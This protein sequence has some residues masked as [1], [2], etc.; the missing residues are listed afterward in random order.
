M[1]TNFFDSNAPKK[2]TNLSINSDLLRQ[3]KERRINISQALEQRLVELLREEKSLRWKE[4]NREAIEDY[5]R[6]TEAHGTF[7][8]G[9][10]RF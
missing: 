9:L 10:R 1:Q 6:R 4:E 7:S 8:D 2:S 3:A 5:N